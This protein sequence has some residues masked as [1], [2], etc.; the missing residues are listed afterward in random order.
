VRRQPYIRLRWYEDLLLRFLASSPRIE[1][2]IV[3]QVVPDDT[4]PDEGPYAG[5]P[6]DFV[7]QLEA[8][9]HAP[10]AEDVGEG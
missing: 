6:V 8:L 7:S 9:Y 2:I 10:S 3:Q 5:A 1:R 4:Y